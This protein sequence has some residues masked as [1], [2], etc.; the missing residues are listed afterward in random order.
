MTRMIPRRS[1][2][3]SVTEPLRFGTKTWW[4]SSVIATAAAMKVQIKSRFLALI[5]PV[6]I[7]PLDRM[8]EKDHPLEGK[9]D[10]KRR[11][12]RPA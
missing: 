4:I 12:V 11:R 7:K 2:R 6:S 5:E 1:R 9:T 8:D 3:T 10:R